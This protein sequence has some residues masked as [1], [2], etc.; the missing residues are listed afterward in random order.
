[1]RSST[2]KKNNNKS[3]TAND[4]GCAT[5]QL[6]MWIKNKDELIKLSSQKKGKKRMRRNGAGKKLIYVDLDSRLLT[7]YRQKRTAPGST[8]T[9]ITDIR[10]EKVTFRYFQ[11]RGRQIS[12][13][14]NHPC[15][16]SKWFGRF[17]VR[18]RLSLQRPK[19]QQK[20]PLDEVHQK[21][22]SFYNYLRR[23]SRWAPK[24]GP[25][26]AFTP[27][28]VFNMDES[29]LA[30]FGDQAKRSINDINT[31][32]E[33]EGCLI[34]EASGRHV[35][36]LEKRFCTVILTV[37][38]EDQRVDP[39]LLFKGKGHI[40]PNE[41]KQYANGIKVT[42]QNYTY[43]PS[44]VDCLSLNINEDDDEEQIQNAATLAAEQD[45]IILNEKNKQLKLTD[46]WKK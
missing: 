45:K 15:P 12:Q 22:T 20:I 28:D 10:K 24:R 14:L 7:W 19:R 23:A 34:S 29:P 33:V 17:L 30:L 26:G 1:M 42:L 6:R 35:I 41:Q 4:I 25:M 46:L 3:K 5:K 32:N 31:C 39:V 44:V 36:F 43:D 2:S 16:S 18:H 9:P 38:G 11:R 40:S 13:E 37:S 27:R 8:T 21:A